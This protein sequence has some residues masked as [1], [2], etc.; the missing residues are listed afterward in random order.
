MKKP[1]IIFSLLIIIIAICPSTGQ[2]L[3]DSS[4]E[5]AFFNESIA[6]SEPNLS[7]IWSV[8]GIEKDPVIMVLNQEGIDLYGQAKY[9]PDSGQAWN[10]IVVGSVQDNRIDLVMT[11]RKNAV[12]FS[13]RLKGTYYV[14]GGLIKGSILQVS[15][16]KVSLRSDFEAM[17]INPDISSY[18]PAREV[19]PSVASASSAKTNATMPKV[20]ESPL[21]ASSQKSRYHDVREDADRIL[22][23]VGDIS[24]IPIGM[25]GL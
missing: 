20:K 24:Q 1:L 6:S 5:T 11:F 15:N 7:F 13:S 9:E 21:P 4:S 10:G 19:A 16:G 2:P 23:G 12:Q 8:T 25:S 14:A 3:N 22:T 17:P 18:T